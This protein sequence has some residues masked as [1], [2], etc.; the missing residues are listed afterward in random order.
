MQILASV[1][2]S[3]IGLIHEGQDVRFTVQAFR[4]RRS[5][6]RCAQVRLQSATTETW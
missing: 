4:A 5:P 2:E 6:A 3:D 1:D